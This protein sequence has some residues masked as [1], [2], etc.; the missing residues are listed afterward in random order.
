MQFFSFCL[1]WAQ[2]KI[3]NEKCWRL[4][5][6]VLLDVTA[7]I[8]VFR[9]T[10]YSSL[11][12]RK[13][14]CTKEWIKEWMDPNAEYTF[15]SNAKMKAFERKLLYVEKTHHQQQPIKELQKCNFFWQSVKP[16]NFTTQDRW[17]TYL[18]MYTCLYS[19]NIVYKGSCTHRTTGEQ[20]SPALQNLG[21]QP[22]VNHRYSLIHC[23]QE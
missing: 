2:E 20:T 8:K 23:A 1:L 7:Q 17:N 18:Y 13:H 12:Y 11:W 10:P 6:L 22:H 9:Y 5:L 19:S 14:H 4:C 16:I 15:K 21:S 3:R